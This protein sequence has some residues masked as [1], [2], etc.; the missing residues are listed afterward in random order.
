MLARNKE[1]ACQKL[2]LKVEQCSIKRLEW[3][4]EEFIEPNQVKQEKLL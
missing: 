2:G 1:E 4:G 3:N